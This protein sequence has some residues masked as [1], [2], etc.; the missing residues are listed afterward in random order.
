MKILI[1]SGYS[2]SS[3]GQKRFQDFVQL[4][5]DVRI[6]HSLTHCIGVQQAEAVDGVSTRHNRAGSLEL[7]R[8]PI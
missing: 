1:V 5:R 8:V 6:A 7:G 2:G 4:I 3:N